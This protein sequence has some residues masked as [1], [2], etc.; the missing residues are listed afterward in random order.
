MAYTPT[1]WGSSD[2]PDFYQ[3]HYPEISVE[4]LNHIEQGIKDAHDLVASLQG[5]TLTQEQI[6]QLNNSINSLAAT[7][8]TFESRI[9]NLEEF[10]ALSTDLANINTAIANLQA[11]VQ[12]LTTNKSDTTHIHDDRY[13]TESEINAALSTKSDTNHSHADLHTHAN[14]SILDTISSVGSGSI[15]TT[16]ERDKLSV[17]ESGAQVNPSI[18]AASDYSLAAMA[19]D[20]LFMIGYSVIPAQ[21]TVYGTRL[22]LQQATSISKVMLLVR[23]AGSGLVTNQCKLGI[24]QN[25][26]LVTQS[27]D[28][29]IVLNTVGIK[30]IELTASVSLLKGAVDVVIVCNGTTLPELFRGSGTTGYV[31]LLLAGQSMRFFTA[32]TGVTTNLPNALGTKTGTTYSYWFGIS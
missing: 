30:Q 4:R 1:N 26:T 15:I 12:S 10:M 32:D 14:K 23:T 11:E 17:I 29:S 24:Y 9:A 2:I 21:G 7:V 5:S 20:P 18:F 22:T 13:F 19:F 28:L 25:N 31:N 3:K 27:G 8:S 6:T 16:A